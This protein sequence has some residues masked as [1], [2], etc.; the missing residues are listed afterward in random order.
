MTLAHPS[1]YLS[2]FILFIPILSIDWF[3]P[4]ILFLSHKS[5]NR[6]GKV[7]LLCLSLKLSCSSLLFLF[8]F[9]CQLHC[10]W[11]ITIA[12]ISL[13]FSLIT[14]YNNILLHRFWWL[15]LVSFPF[16]MIILLFFFFLVSLF[17]SSQSSFLF[18]ILYLYLG[19]FI[20]HEEQRDKWKTLHFIWKKKE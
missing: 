10:E 20:F 7:C 11:M 4:V 5:Q 13:Y 16:I 3:F 1:I 19:Y 9:I 14:I 6:T 8:L 15:I 12:S 18:L 2:F 17:L